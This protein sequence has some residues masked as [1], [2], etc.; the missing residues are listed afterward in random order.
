MRVNLLKVLTAGFVIVALI[1]NTVVFSAADNSGIDNIEEELMLL[2]R[3]NIFK[4]EAEDEDGKIVSDK[5]VTRRE[6]AKFIVKFMGLWKDGEAAIESSP[7]VDV[8]GSNPDDGYI[9]VC[10]DMGIVNGYSDWTY[11]PDASIKADEFLKMLI[12]AMGHNL[13]AESMGGYPVGYYMAAMN[14]GIKS[15]NTS[16]TGNDITMGEVIMLMSQAL[17]CNAGNELGNYV[18]NATVLERFHNTKKTY[19]IVTGTYYTHLTNARPLPAKNHIEI[20]GETY[21][22]DFEYSDE[23]LGYNVNC[24]VSADDEKIVHIETTERNSSLY[25]EGKDIVEITSNSFRYINENGKEKKAS[26]KSSCDIIYN[27]KALTNVS[28]ESDK[29][30]PVNG[31]ATLLDNDND[32]VYDV[33]VITSYED[34]V[35]SSV[36]KTEYKVYDKYRASV[37]DL[38]SEENEVIILNTDGKTI[39][40]DSITE[41]NVLSIARSEEYN[42]SAIITVIVSSSSVNGKIERVNQDD[43]YGIGRKEYMRSPNYTVPIHVGDAGNFYLNHKGMIAG[44]N[45]PESVYGEYAYLTGASKKGLNETVSVKI[46][47]TYG[48]FEI[49]E[50]SENVRID[51]NKSTPENSVSVL[52]PQLIKFKLDENDKIYYIDT[53]NVGSNESS[54][55]LTKDISAEDFYYETYLMNG[56]YRLTANTFIFGIPSDATDY[57]AY[58]ISNRGNLSNTSYSFDGYDANEVNEL[59]A[60]IIMDY[61]PAAAISNTDTAA[62]LVTS[63]QD[64]MDDAG[65]VF[66]RIDGITRSNARV[67]LKLKD[68]TLKSTYNLKTGDVARFSY[69]GNHN[70]LAIEKIYNVDGTSGNSALIAPN[71]GVYY[72]STSFSSG[73]QMLY[74]NVVERVGNTILFNSNGYLQVFDIQYLKLVKYNQRTGQTTECTIDDIGRN[75]EMLVQSRYGLIMLAVIMEGAQ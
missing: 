22:V 75:T 43:T 3:L 35:V 72:S 30:K 21:E 29:L 11:N 64:V 61:V 57:D 74:G 19:G 36:N 8:D 7:F 65:D 44:F 71:N 23:L 49:Y 51:G 24:Y 6:A 13:R 26:I 56:Q 59:S 52:T 48:T 50:L 2:K 12:T 4:S 45:P 25:I 63:V 5:T 60:M 1:F 73:Y 17:V 67:S 55:C 31:D 33:I 47:T 40:I 62:T 34:Y 38:S 32:G 14:V 37:L 70:I 69:D 53:V 18:T 68:D 15:L 46:Y 39:G 9:K 16:G 27:K 20:N 58:T 28:I 10:Y 42:G 66:C 54:E 41:W